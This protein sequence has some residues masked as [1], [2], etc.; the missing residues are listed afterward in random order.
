MSDKVEKLNSLRQRTLREEIS[1]RQK[2]VRR[3]PH[4]A[5]TDLQLLGAVS[6]PR[7]RSCPYLKTRLELLPPEVKE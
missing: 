5:S 3:S 1:L 2:M 7:R 4:C 6:R